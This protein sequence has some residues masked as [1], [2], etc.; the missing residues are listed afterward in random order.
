MARTF[1]GKYAWMARIKRVI[2][3]YGISTSCSVN[4]NFMVGSGKSVQ[5]I[6]VLLRFSFLGQ[7][8]TLLIYIH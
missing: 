6:H 3:G 8:Q 1:G 5:L 7:Y 2:W 4:V